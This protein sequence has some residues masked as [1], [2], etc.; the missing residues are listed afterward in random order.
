MNHHPLGPSVANYEIANARISGFSTFLGGISFIA[1]VLSINI[2]SGR[3]R[4]SSTIELAAGTLVFLLL[5]TAMILFLSS[6][7]TL[8]AVYT[9]AE[10]DA[11]SS[12]RLARTF[13][14]AGAVLMFWAA[15]AL[16]LVVFWPSVESGAYA[17]AAVVGSLVFLRLRTLLGRR[18]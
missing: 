8:V 1:L 3:L 18:S 17:A 11:A 10:R 13:I 15:G 9:D 7:V 5:L 16:M 6:T 2:L 4:D 12:V 14:G